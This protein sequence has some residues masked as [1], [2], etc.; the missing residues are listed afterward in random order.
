MFTLP[1]LGQGIP[2]LSYTRKGGAF[3]KKELFLIILVTG[4]IP[5]AM[6]GQ[7]DN[8]RVYI[9]DS[10]SWSTSGGFYG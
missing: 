2:F 6:F 10:D 5:L 3:M 1:V 7:Q 9:T 8:V 4:L